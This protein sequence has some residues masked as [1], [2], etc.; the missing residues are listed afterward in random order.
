MVNMK[1]GPLTS[2][3]VVNIKVGPLTYAAFGPPRRWD[4]GDR[5]TAWTRNGWVTGRIAVLYPDY[6]VDVLDSRGRH[7]RCPWMALPKNGGQS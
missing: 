3:A 4:I 1:H 2:A 7:W 6:G 5:V